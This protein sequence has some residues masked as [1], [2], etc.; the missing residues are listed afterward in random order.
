MKE[1]I[2]DGGVKFVHP[3]KDIPM[4]NA[5]MKAKRIAK[6]GAELMSKMIFLMEF[7]EKLIKWS[8]ISDD[9]IAAEDE[10]PD[11]MLL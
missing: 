4:P 6:T 10:P 7:S 1:D 11:D 5:T 8:S 2:E 9:N 3:Q